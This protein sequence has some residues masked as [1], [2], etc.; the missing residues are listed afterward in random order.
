MIIIIFELGISNLYIKSASLKHVKLR[1]SLRETYTFLLFFFSIFGGPN[2][3]GKFH[4]GSWE[5]I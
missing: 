4:F 1:I 3:M 2:Y 5:L